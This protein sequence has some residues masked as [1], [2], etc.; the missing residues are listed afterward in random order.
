M[1]A[2]SGSVAF[3]SYVD[4]DGRLKQAMGSDFIHTAENRVD[5]YE[6]IHGLNNDDVSYRVV[7]PITFKIGD[8]VEAILAFSVVPVTPQDVQNGRKKMI[9]S[10]RSLALLDNTQR[11]N[12]AMI[13]MQARAS[14]TTTMRYLAP[15]TNKR[16]RVRFIDDSADEEESIMGLK[17]LQLSGKSEKENTGY[18][19]P[20][21]PI[22]GMNIDSN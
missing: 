19:G 8:I 17:R 7:D 18:S 6:M 9:I 14:T 1:A 10:L 11:T 15:S 12:A 3:A 21:F 20:L 4:P 13:E 22:A 2:R 16:R 5:Y